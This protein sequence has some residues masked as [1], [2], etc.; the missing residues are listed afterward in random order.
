MIGQTTALER[1]AWAFTDF[2]GRIEAVSTGARRLFGVENLR[3]GDDLLY[4]LPL[5]RR[6]LLFDIEVAMTGWPAQRSVTIRHT[7]EQTVT[8]QYR[9]S[10]R[11]ER[12]NAGGGLYW[13]LRAS[14]S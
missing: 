3:R 7:E 4:Y 8:L 2:A 14:T 1:E 11:L 12:P 6:A 5:P 13:H 10:R 9:V